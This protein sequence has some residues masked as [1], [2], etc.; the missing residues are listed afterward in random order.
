MTAGLPT[1][2]V[3]M[4]S[5]CLQTQAHPHRSTGLTL[6]SRQT[7]LRGSFQTGRLPERQIGAVNFA[8]MKDA[9][10]SVSLASSVQLNGLPGTTVARPVLRTEGLEAKAS[11]PR[12]AV[13]LERVVA[14]FKAAKQ[15]L[16]REFGRVPGSAGVSVWADPASGCREAVRR[17]PGA[18]AAR[19]VQLLCD[20]MSN[21]GCQTK[22]EGD[23]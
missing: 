19:H 5:M 13:S 14:D 17:P 12:I 11:R 23:G 7:M 21:R 3:A 18:G 6:L 16:A 10:M 9:F 1:R 15:L 22:G 2:L 20:C 8:P 4:V